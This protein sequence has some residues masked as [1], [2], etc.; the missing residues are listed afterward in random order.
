L[1][2]WLSWAREVLTSHGVDPTWQRRTL[3]DMVGLT[4]AGRSSPDGGRGE[5]L[6]RVAAF[7]DSAALRSPEWHAATLQVEAM[8][9]VVAP[10][11][12]DRGPDRTERLVMVVGRI[13]AQIERER[14][15]PDA[16]LGRKLRQRNRHAAQKGV[17]E[18]RDNAAAVQ[19][20]IRRAVA[21]YRLSS[22]D[23]PRRQMARD[24]AP[25]LR[26]GV[27]ALLNRLRRLGL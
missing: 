10:A 2:F 26:L 5:A 6:A 17:Q 14:L 25:S 15:H 9:P 7:R 24:L 23:A 8:M 13:L 3:A 27:G 18:R 20:R 19:D 11:Y 1:P 12:G 4:E 21:R 22:A 16:E